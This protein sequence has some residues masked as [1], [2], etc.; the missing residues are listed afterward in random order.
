MHLDSTDNAG[1]FSFDNRSKEKFENNSVLSE[2]VR[3][4]ETNAVN[5]TSKENEI[6]NHGSESG[7]YEYRGVLTGNVR[8]IETQTYIEYKVV[9]LPEKIK[10]ENPA[11]NYEVNPRYFD[12]VPKVETYNTSSYIIQKSQ[13]E[14]TILCRPLVFCG[15]DAYESCKNITFSTCDYCR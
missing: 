2:I 6:W 1:N 4:S 10:V 13:R 9:M 8:N 7:N 11:N 12:N 15:Y 14:N 3:I 5:E